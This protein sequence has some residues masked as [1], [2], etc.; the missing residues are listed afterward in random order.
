MR[1]LPPSSRLCCTGGRPRLV[2]GHDGSIQ[3]GQVAASAAACLLMPALTGPGA[4]TALLDD[5]D[6]AELPQLLAAVTESPF[7]EVRMI[8][9][10]N[11]GPVWTARCGPGPQG[12]A[13]CRHAIAWAQS[14]PEPGTWR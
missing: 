3:R 12:S 7:T 11:L 4:N 10:R 1:Q 6:L 8:L 5:D 13:R 9:A 14:K 2:R